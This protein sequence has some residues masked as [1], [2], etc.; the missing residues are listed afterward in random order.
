MDVVRPGQHHSPAQPAAQ[1]E[2][3]EQDRRHGQPDEGQP[4]N[5][6]K[7]EDA[8]EEGHRQEHEPTHADRIEEPPAFDGPL[9]DDESGSGKRGAHQQR[10]RGEDERQPPPAADERQAEASGCGADAQRDRAPEA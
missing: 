2:P 10:A 5:S 7:D 3:L 6:R 9:A 8:H 4:E 1:V